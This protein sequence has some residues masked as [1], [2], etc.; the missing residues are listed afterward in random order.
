M[1]S[2][3]ETKQESTMDPLQQEI[4]EDL[5]GRT[6][7]IADSPFAGY[8]DPLVAGMD[9]M[10]RQAYEGYGALTLPSEYGAAS[11][12]YAGMAAETPEQRME[13]VR[14]YQ[15]MYTEGVIDPMLAQAE[16]KRAQERVGEAAGVTKAG[17]F[18]NVRRGVFEGEREAAY[19]TSRDAMVAGLMQQGLSFG[20]AQVAEENQ[21]RIAGAQGMVGAAGAGRQAELGALGAQMSAGDIARQIEQAG[22]GADYEQFIR[23]QQYPLQSLA[24][25]FSTAGLIP[26]G[27]GTGTTT[28]RSPYGGLSA[29]GGMLGG[30]GSAGQGYAAMAPLLSD[31]RLKENI[32]PQGSVNG[33]NFY[34]WNWNDAAKKSGL[35][36]G[37]TFGVM[38]QELE[39]SHPDLV[40]VGDHGYRMVNY[41]GVED[42][43]GVRAG[44]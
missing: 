43:T 13:R 23:E 26:A 30:L 16:R 35:G 11:D 39:K 44:G 2:T 38:A 8:T 20:E 22:L 14:G 10:T 17:A 37:I 28:E 6:T 7:A 3:T 32:T 41:S 33:I 9:P 27:I 21:A 15:D 1:G 18:G 25:L 29:F 4:I 36:E 42:V 19:E 5:Y 34:T 24:G 31:V 12:I 40:V